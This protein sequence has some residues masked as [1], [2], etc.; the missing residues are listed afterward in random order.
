MAGHFPLSKYSEPKIF[1]AV[2]LMRGKIVSLC[3][4]LKDFEKTKFPFRGINYELM[5]LSK[6]YCELP[7]NQIACMLGK[8]S[9]E[10]D[11]EQHESIVKDISLECHF[12]K[13]TKELIAIYWVA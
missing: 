8:F 11:M 12:D 6:D 10:D 7:D 13:H 5:K 1:N 9:L 3:N 2:T 4:L